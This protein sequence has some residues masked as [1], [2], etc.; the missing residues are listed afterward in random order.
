MPRTLCKSG[1]CSAGRPALRKPWVAVHTDVIRRRKRCI[2][3]CGRGR[4]YA[5]F[6]RLVGGVQRCNDGMREA[7]VHF[8]HEGERLVRVD[9]F[10]YGAGRGRGSRVESL[11]VRVSSIVAEA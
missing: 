5:V 2:S 8:D 10:W 7:W 11:S 6:E 9:G 3:A 4:G 1:F